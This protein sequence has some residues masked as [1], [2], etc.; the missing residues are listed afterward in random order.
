MC[1]RSFFSSRS[2]LFRVFLLSLM[3]DMWERG[4]SVVMR[5]FRAINVEMLCIVVQGCEE[6]APKKLFLLQSATLAMRLFVSNFQYV[7]KNTSSQKERNRSRRTNSDGNAAGAIKVKRR[8]EEKESQG[9]GN[10]EQGQGVQTRTPGWHCISKEKER[11]K[12]QW[13]ERPG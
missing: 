7:V 3:H 9:K 4:R 11:E 10:K 2:F 6:H 13:V 5:L 12:R 8:E 1:V